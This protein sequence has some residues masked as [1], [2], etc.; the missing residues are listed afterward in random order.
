VAYVDS[1][2]VATHNVDKSF[3]SSKQAVH[4]YFVEGMY[5]WLQYNGKG[6]VR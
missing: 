1:D 3:F 2:S 4:P 6:G 5:D